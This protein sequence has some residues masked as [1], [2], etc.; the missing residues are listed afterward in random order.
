MITRASLVSMD[1]IKS[2]S[3]INGKNEHPCKNKLIKWNNIVLVKED[4]QDR[5]DM[6]MYVGCEDSKK[7]SGQLFWLKTFNDNIP[8]IE[9]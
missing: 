4:L 6:W 3:W 9:D 2:S 5:E 1:F 8:I 7:I